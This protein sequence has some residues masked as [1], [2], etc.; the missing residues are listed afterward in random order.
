MSRRSVL[1]LILF[2]C[3]GVTGRELPEY[4]VL[5][6]EVSN[7]GDVAVYNLQP[8]LTACSR[9][10]PC[11]LRESPALGRVSFVKCLAASHAA[12]SAEHFGADLL[13]LIEQQRL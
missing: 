10:A 5:A 11:D 8:R 9:A 13:H 3:I 12:T 4:M 1:Y 2:L 7:D 6:D